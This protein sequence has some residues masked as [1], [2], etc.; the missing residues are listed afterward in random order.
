MRIER[1][2][3]HIAPCSATDDMNSPIY[4]PI[5]IFVVAIANNKIFKKINTG[6]QKVNV[7]YAGLFFNEL[8]CQTNFRLSRRVRKSANPVYQVIGGI[9][10]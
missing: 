10:Y 8:I 7:R 9:P 3:N 4:S 2:Q 6:G 5:L 1:R